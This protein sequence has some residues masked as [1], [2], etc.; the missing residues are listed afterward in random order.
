MARTHDCRQIRGKTLNL[1]VF[2]IRLRTLQAAASLQACKPMLSLP[3]PPPF[4]L[5]TQQYDS[6]MTGFALVGPWQSLQ[7]P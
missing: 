1:G 6:Q 2:L 4:D 3:T 7:D 5:G